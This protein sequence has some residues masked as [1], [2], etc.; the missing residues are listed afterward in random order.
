MSKSLPFNLAISGSFIFTSSIN[1]LSLF[2]GVFDLEK[3]NILWGNAGDIG[4]PYKGVLAES[5]S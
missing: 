1:N 4:K 2:L 3:V 5:L